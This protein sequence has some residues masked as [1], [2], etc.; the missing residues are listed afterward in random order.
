MQGNQQAPVN[1]GEEM[2]CNVGTTDRVIRI[3]LGII[4]IALGLSHVVG[5]DGNRRLCCW[6]PRT[7]DWRVSLLP[8]V[9]GFWNQYV[10]AEAQPNK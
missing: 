4:L 7:G 2:T 8:S 5:G 1:G 3:V 9:V 10:P 6:S